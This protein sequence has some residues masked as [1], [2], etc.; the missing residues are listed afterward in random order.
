MTK[1]R[2]IIYAVAALL[3]AFMIGGFLGNKAFAQEPCPAADGPI[4]N[5]HSAVKKP[6]DPVTLSWTTPVADTCGDPLGGPSALTEIQLFVEVDTPVTDGT[7]AA[8][9]YPPGQ[10]SVGLTADAQKGADIYYALRACND[11]GCSK[12]SNQEYVKLPGNPNAP[13]QQKLQ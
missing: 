1:K 5:V 4:A 7:P 8:A 9:T 10:T 12:L 11:I 3:I 6:G 13:G 2:A